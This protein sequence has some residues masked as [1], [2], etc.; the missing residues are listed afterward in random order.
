MIVFDLICANEH[1][2][3]AWFPDSKAFDRQRRKKAV[4]CPVCGDTKVQKAL[5]A[6]NIATSEKREATAKSKAVMAA[7]TMRALAEARKHIE[8]NCENV[9]DRFAEEARKIHYGETEKRDIY[10]QASKDEAEALRD[11][12]V[13]FAE[14]PWVPRMDN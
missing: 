3:E 14:I 4:E 8:E 1:T 11:E 10:G 9:G 13:E 12:G 2:F 5:M 7:Q 6:P